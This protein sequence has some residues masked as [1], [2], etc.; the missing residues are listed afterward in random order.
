M[1]LFFAITLLVSASANAQDKVTAATE[2]GKPYIL[3]TVT[4]GESI[5][6]LGRNY[7]IA[8]KELAAFNKVDMAKGL[9]LGQEVRI[10]LTKDNLFLAPCTVCKKVFYTVP[11]KEGLYRIAVS[12]NNMGLPNLKKMNSLTT[13]NVSIGQELLVGYLKDTEAAAITVTTPKTEIKEAVPA[14]PEPV[15]QV[16]K[17]VTPPQKE[18]VKKA[19]PVVNIVKETKSDSG[20]IAVNTTV[21]EVLKSAFESQYL[22]K[23]TNSVSGTAAIFKSTSG[24]ND[25]KFYV[26]MNNVTPGTIVK[27]TAP[28]TNK[29]LFAKVLGELPAIRQNESILI[30]ISNA[31]AA[32]L[33]GGEEDIQVVVAF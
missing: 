28:T 20:I 21:S 32:L 18:V 13:D 3:K 26:L 2:N 30:R 9:K 19:E 25:D 14:K 11:P 8:P 29:T 23:G 10:P 24:W 15:K 22:G 6:S 31:A 33:G 12:F 1:R 27:I 7:S 16:I 17:E 4:A 5:F